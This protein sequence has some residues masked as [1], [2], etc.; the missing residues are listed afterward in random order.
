MTSPQ[1]TMGT[2]GGQPTV[3]AANTRPTQSVA[4][5]V[6]EGEKSASRIVMTRAG[7]IIDGGERD[8]DGR[9]G[10]LSR[11]SVNRATSLSVMAGVNMSTK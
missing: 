4:G 3:V 5:R 1:A 10:R 7:R 6:T 9:R 2:A 8:R 11:T